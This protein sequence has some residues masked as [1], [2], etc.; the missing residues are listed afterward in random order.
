MEYTDDVVDKEIYC[1]SSLVALSTNHEQLP[2]ECQLQDNNFLHILEC[3][4][5]PKSHYLDN[6]TIIS[7]L[8]GTLLFPSINF[9]EIP[10][11]ENQFVPS[12]IYPVESPPTMVCIQTQTPT[13]PFTSKTKLRVDPVLLL[14]SSR[15]A[16][17]ALHPN[18]PRQDPSKF[19][20]VERILGQKIESRGDSS[21]INICEFYQTLQDTKGKKLREI[22]LNLYDVLHVNVRKDS[23]N[24]KMIRNN[25]NF[26][27]KNMLESYP[28]L[29]FYGEAKDF[30]L[31]RLHVPEVLITIEDEILRQKFQS[32]PVGRIAMKRM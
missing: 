5:P 25:I 15:P 1:V 23:D 9:Q 26:K 24:I 27:I 12:V 11:N 18:I 30:N 28:H 31:T 3:A 13:P 29:H 10:E 14:T 17:A 4:T 32:T 20:D 2:L 16:L 6:Q 22:Y 21:H 19:K 7:N 8:D